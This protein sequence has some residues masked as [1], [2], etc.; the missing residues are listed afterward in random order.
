MATS[1]AGSRNPLLLWKTRAERGG[2]SSDPGAIISSRLLMASRGRRVQPEP[3]GKLAEIPASCW[4]RVKHLMK[5]KK[6]FVNLPTACRAPHW[7]ERYPASWGFPRHSSRV[8]RGKVCVFIKLIIL[9]IRPNSFPAELL[10][11]WLDVSSS[12]DLCNGLIF[13]PKSTTPSVSCLWGIVKSPVLR[14]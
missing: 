2:G 8:L 4:S 5:Q 7:K 3:N 11:L 10:S 13:E 12:L 1:W 9:C 6:G 14:A